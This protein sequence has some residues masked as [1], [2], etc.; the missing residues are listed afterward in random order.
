M[1]LVIPG[2]LINWNVKYK[3]G[4]FSIIKNRKIH[5]YSYLVR[6]KYLKSNRKGDNCSKDNF[7][8]LEPRW[9]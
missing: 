5:F 6:E 9:K 1:E 7:S 2:S 4:F 3:C 8:Y